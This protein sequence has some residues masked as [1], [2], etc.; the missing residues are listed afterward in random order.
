MRW[1][2][3]V[4]RGIRGALLCYLLEESEKEDIRNFAALGVRML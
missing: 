2:L 1:E 4:K 3:L